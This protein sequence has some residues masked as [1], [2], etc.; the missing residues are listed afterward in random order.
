MKVA[1][2]ACK[3]S[4]IDRPMLLK[5]NSEMSR[6]HSMRFSVLAAVL[7]FFWYDSVIHDA[8]V[9]INDHRMRLPGTLEVECRSCSSFNFA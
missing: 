7:H 4:A 3:M 8:C 6:R 2:M 9:Y 5:T 1:A